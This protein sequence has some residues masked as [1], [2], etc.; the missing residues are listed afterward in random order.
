MMIDIDVMQ[1]AKEEKE[2]KESFLN[3][4]SFII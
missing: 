4:A 1:E 2:R 3:A